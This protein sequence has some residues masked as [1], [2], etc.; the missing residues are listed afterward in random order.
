MSRLSYAAG[1]ALPIAV[2][3]AFVGPAYTGAQDKPAGEPFV[4]AMPEGFRPMDTR[5][6]GQPER[7]VWV[8]ASLGDGGLTPN[9]SITHVNDMG[10]FD[11]AKLS[12]IASGMPAFFE[13]GKVKWREVRHA[14]IARHDGAL[15]GLLE[16]ENTLGEER[17]RSL[18]I[19]FPD[20]RGASLVTANFPS[21]EA[22]H[23]V[24]IFEA[25]IERSRGVATRGIR[26]PPWVY[27][28]WG[29]GAGGVSFMLLALLAGR[30]SRRVAPA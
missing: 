23:W 27:V 13:A 28:A 21:F 29:A 11:D 16:G 5:S 14:Q 20:D 18:Q 8:H 24:P 17:Y 7:S 19:S 15:V 2:V 1:L 30:A 12:L 22:S 4:Y 6:G 10:A 26:K 3:A 25:A 9:V